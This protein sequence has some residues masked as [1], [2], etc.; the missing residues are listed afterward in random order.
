MFYTFDEIP[1]PPRLEFKNVQLKDQG[2]FQ[3][4]VQ[5]LESRNEIAKY[6]G[7]VAKNEKAADV[8][9][10][11]YIGSLLPVSIDLVC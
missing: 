7:Q 2:S 8:A 5:L 11:S 1:V 4:I 3:R 6:I 10:M 9:D